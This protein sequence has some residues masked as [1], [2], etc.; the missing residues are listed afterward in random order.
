MFRLQN[1]EYLYLLLA[2]PILIG[3]FLWYWNRRRAALDR[4]ADREMME[5]LAPGMNRRL[6]WTKF[7]LLLISIPLLSVAMTNPQ[8]AAERQEVKR[9]GIDV[10]LALDVSNSMLAEDVQP[11]RMER[12]R[13]FAT[14][15][16]D[17][18]VGN[19]IGIELFTCTSL[20]QAPLTT[21]YAFIKSVIS[22][23]GPY[24]ISAQGTNLGEAIDRAEEAYEEGSANHRALIIISDGEDHDG[25]AAAAANRAHDAGLMIYTIGVGKQESSFMPL[26]LP[27]GRKDYVRQNGGGPATTNADPATLEAIASAGGGNYFPLSGDSKNLAEAIKAKVDGIEKQEFESQSFSTYDSYFYWFLAPAILLL[28]FEFSIGRKDR[29]RAAELEI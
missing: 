2:V 14:T 19:N 26:D 16:V 10:I 8:W 17:E 20:M 18:L 15:L 1:P 7:I 29:K 22:T 23:A 27:N 3:L 11:S 9:R 12:A 4:F 21:D 24:Q 25:S 5:Q 28:L 6:P 13:Y